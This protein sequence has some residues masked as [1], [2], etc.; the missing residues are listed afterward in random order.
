M[1]SHIDPQIQYVYD[2]WH[3]TVRARDLSATA[4]LYAEDAVLETPLLL[5]VYPDRQ[6]G[7]LVG[8]DNI[9]RFFDDG[10]RKFSN[11]LAQWFRTDVFFVNGR[12]LAWEYPR[13]TPNG[14]QVD[15]MEMMEI[16]DGHIAAHRVYWGWYG[17]NLLAPA[18][19]ARD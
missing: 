4:A 11:D 10:V 18:L 19:K 17:V 6:S 9:R 12:R 14:D 8:R 2:K 5:A 15:L 3:E 1:T 16:E 13:A 7:V